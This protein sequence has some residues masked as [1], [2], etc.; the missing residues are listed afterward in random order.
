MKQDIYQTDLIA[1]NDSQLLDVYSSTVT[2][3]VKSTSQ[4]VVHI[5]VIKKVQDQRTRKLTEQGAAGS[6]FVIS[7]DGYII[8]NN[9]VIED[10]L[11]IRVAFG[12]ELK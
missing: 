1:S 6:G 11:N 3:V 8:T 2:S 12:G 9:H 7:S 10:A 4:A 5:S